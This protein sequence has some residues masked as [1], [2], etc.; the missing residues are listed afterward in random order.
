MACT[1]YGNTQATDLRLQVLQL[2]SALQAQEIHQDSRDKLVF[3]LMNEILSDVV[4][5]RTQDASQRM[6]SPSPLQGRVF[7][8]GAPTNNHVHHKKKRVQGKRHKIP[9]FD[10]YYVNSM[11]D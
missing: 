10:F 8:D 3:G 9:M 4:V 7:F 5:Y 6:P 1:Y 2:K 11:L